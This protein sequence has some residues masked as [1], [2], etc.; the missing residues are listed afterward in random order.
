MGRRTSLA[1]LATEK[2]ED[3]P[4]HSVATLSRLR[5]A[6]IAATPLNPRRSFGAPEE[7]AALGESIRVRQL[8]PVV[9]VSRSAYLKLWP[10]H[11]EHI[12]NAAH[13]LVNGERRFRAALQVSLERLDVLHREEVADS[14]ETFLDA[15]LT[16]NLDRKN[17]DPIEEAHAV[18]AMVNE[19]GSATAAAER[20]RR[21][22]TWVS[23]RRALLKL[24]PHLQEKVRGGELPVRIA[25]SIAALAHDEQEAAWE[26]T[27]AQEAATARKREQE[28]S[29]SA[30]RISRS[31]TKVPDPRTSDVHSP[32][33]NFTAARDPDS[34]LSSGSGGAAHNSDGAVPWHSPESLA[35]LIRR[36]VEPE[37]ITVLIELLSA[38]GDTTR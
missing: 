7:L 21:H 13:V 19:C 20:L 12:G 38:D 29:G 10:E 5:P 33:S 36:R 25:R 2:I 37:H 4:G 24:A 35:T 3:V 30:P 31:P 15:L 18:E 32:A 34:A 16:E 23:Q 8:Q 6:Q 1:S 17:F 14:R 26:S 11:E 28:R 9:V 27:R 22:K